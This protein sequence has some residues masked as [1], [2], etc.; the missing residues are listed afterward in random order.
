MCDC[1]IELKL[2]RNALGMGMFFAFETSGDRYARHS[3][4]GEVKYYLGQEY[5]C[6]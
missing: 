6:L 2:F 1:S 4:H 3:S 5:S